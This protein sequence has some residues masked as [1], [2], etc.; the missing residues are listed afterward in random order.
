LNPSTD[1]LANNVACA[2]NPVG[3]VEPQLAVRLRVICLEKPLQGQAMSS[4]NIWLEGANVE[5]GHPLALLQLSV[6]MLSVNASLSCHETRIDS[7]MRVAH[8]LNKYGYIL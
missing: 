1:L 4:P 6:N 8:F 5:T 7:A 3:W 2:A